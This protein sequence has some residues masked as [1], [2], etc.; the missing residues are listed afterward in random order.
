MEHNPEYDHTKIKDLIVGAGV[1]AEVPPYFSEGIHKRTTDNAGEDLEDKAIDVADR[2]MD[3]N[4]D[5]LALD[6]AKAAMNWLGKGTKARTTIF[7]Q[8]AQVN[9][10]ASDPEKSSH[11]LTSLRD[12][13]SLLTQGQKIIGDN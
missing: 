7:A 5:K 2:V 9:Q 11:I 3:S 8:N 1:P 10:L 6:A 12:S 4:D 13:I